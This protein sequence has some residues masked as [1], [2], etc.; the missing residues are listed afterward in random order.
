MKLVT[1]ACRGL[2]EDDLARVD[3]MLGREWLND[4]SR[5]TVRM[6]CAE[7]TAIA[8]GCHGMK[9]LS[10]TGSQWRATSRTMLVLQ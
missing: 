4:S 8:G 6:L 2:P 7:R 3:E 9:P 1:E 5:H 10:R